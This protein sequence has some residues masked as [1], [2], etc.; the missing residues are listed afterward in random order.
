M[1][2]AELIQPVSGEFRFDP[3]RYDHPIASPFRGFERAGLVSVPIWQYMRLRLFAENKANVALWSM[4][5]SGVCALLTAL[6]F[7]GP[8]WLTFLVIFLWGASV[9]PDSA[10]FSAL[11]ADNAPP[12]QAGSLMTLQTALGFG[13]TFFT[14]Q[15]TPVLA[16][17]WG[18]PAVIALM[19]L[20]PVFG[21]VAMA[22][23]KALA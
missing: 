2:P 13:L 9:I 20:G 15:A 5:V 4:V 10:Q 3:Q 21:I 14:V 12:H 1:L 11:V 6:T 22:R 8:V 18:W 23:L 16:A 19:A 7:G 17:W